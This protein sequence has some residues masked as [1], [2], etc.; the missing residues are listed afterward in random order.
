MNL[1]RHLQHISDLSC[2]TLKSLEFKDLLNLEISI[3]LS[4]CEA[5][6]RSSSPL[7]E[8]NLSD[9][10]TF[11][12]WRLWPTRQHL[13]LPFKCLDYLGWNIDDRIQGEQKLIGFWETVDW[14]E[15][16]TRKQI[17]VLLRG[18]DRRACQPGGGGWSMALDFNN[19]HMAA[20]SLT[21]MEMSKPCPH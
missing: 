7:R 15:I 13:E 6:I 12:F 3:F 20:V 5:Q 8:N 11:C 10:P 21:G 2:S 1:E 14:Q 19:Y 16:M 17:G 4:A 18:F 9:I